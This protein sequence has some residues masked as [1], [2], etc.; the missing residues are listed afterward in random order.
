MSSSRFDEAA[1]T[2]DEQPV[3]LAMTRRIIE[4]IRA[5]VPLSP[6]M[7]ALDYGCGTGLVTM[8]LAE[9]VGRIVGMDSSPGM[10]AKLRE[11]IASLDAAN[12]ETCLWDLTTTTPPAHL[13]VNLIVSAMTL[14]HIA[15]IPTLLQALDAM[16]LPGGWIALADLDTEDGS[17]HSDPTGVQHHGI[18]RDW[19]QAQ[20]TA[21]GYQ[22]VHA[23]TATTVDRPRDD[24]TSRHYP[25]FLVRGHKPA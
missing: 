20:L 1:A 24:G 6:A 17:F 19:L 12:V 9:S 22:D 5:Q 21:L 16:L 2:W 7:T 15:D 14:H 18:D 10:L 8:A 4:A 13:R 3:R 25:V 11:K 23:V